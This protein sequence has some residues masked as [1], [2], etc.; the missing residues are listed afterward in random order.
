MFFF[1]KIINFFIY[2]SFYDEISGKNLFI[3]YCSACHQNGQNIILPEKNLRLKTL[4]LNGMDNSKSILYQIINGKN[5]MPAFGG[6]LNFEEIEKITTYILDESE[7]NPT[8]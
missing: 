2:L 7:Y 8:N 6:R 4:K 3:Q 5:G 1:K